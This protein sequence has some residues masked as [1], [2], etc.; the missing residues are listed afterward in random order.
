MFA[1]IAF[2]LL[3][4]LALAF[5]EPV[6]EWKIDGK[7]LTDHIETM[8][9]NGWFVRT[10]PDH[11]LECLH[12]W[13]RDCEV[14]RPL[15][16]SVELRSAN[17]QSVSYTIDFAECIPGVQATYCVPLEKLRYLPCHLPDSFML[18]DVSIYS[19][20]SPLNGKGVMKSPCY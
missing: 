6:C 18:S 15:S 9:C 11:R 10:N 20:W 1:R 7:F 14:E 17:L 5:R 19:N 2:V 13:L 8:E 12:V 4:P 16:F 3:L